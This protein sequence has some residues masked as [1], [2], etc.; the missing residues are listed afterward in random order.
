MLAICDGALESQKCAWST[1]KIKG[2]GYK[3]WVDEED[4]GVNQ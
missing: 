4:S 2:Y 1:K 3:W